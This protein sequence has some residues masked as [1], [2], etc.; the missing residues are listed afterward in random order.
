MRRIALLFLIPLLLTACGSTPTSPEN[1]STSVYYAGSTS[2]GVW[3]ALGLAGFELVDQPDQADVIVLNGTVPNPGAVAEQVADGAGLVL[4]MGEAVTPSDFEIILKFPVSLELGEDAVSLTEIEVDDP[5]TREVIWN[6]APQVRERIDVMHPI[7]SVQP[8]A[9][10]Y[11][12]G[13]WILWQ[14][15]PTVFVINAIL[16]SEQTNPQLQ[17]WAYFNYLVYHLVSRAAGEA[18]LSFADYPGSPLPHTT[19]RNFLWLVLAVMN[20]TSFGVF[21]L[22]RRYSKNH[23]EILHQ[24]VVDRGSFESR[25]AHSSWE[26]VGFHRPLGGFLVALSIGLILFI[27]IIIY[28]NLI[29]PVY[30]LPSAQALGIWGRVVQF[31]NF[32]WLFF[33]MG[34]SIAFI[35]YLSQYRV[36]DPAKGIQFGQ[37]FVWWQALSGTIQVAL[38]V[39]I[40]STLAP[41]SAYA[42]Y[43]WSVILHAFI[44][45]PG[46]YQ[47]MRHALSGF[48][49]QDYARYLDMGFYQVFP[50]L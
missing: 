25:E 3:S 40:A 50:M 8:L 2:S 32:A 36:E 47:V 28:Q 44:Q 9:V 33:D 18:P 37:V 13:D 19:E 34:T 31:F 22:V 20:L 35:K 39:A 5:L 41:R 21:Y 26:D 27:P 46:F 42:L 30:I 4:I 10:A 24:I 29:L 6:S 23:P 14:V 17:Q 43:A 38:V 48:Q 12:S 15:R 45:V 11:E 1:L 16:E 49:R 7:S